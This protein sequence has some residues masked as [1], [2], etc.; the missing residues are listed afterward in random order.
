MFK[1][2][3]CILFACGLSG[4]A[5]LSVEKRTQLDDLAENNITGMKATY[6]ALEEKLETAAGYLALDAR[7]VKIPFI[8]WGGGKGVL[9][10]T[11]SGQKTYVKASR[12]D[13]GGGG[14]LREFD[15]L[16][17]IYDEKLLKIP[18]V[19]KF[20]YG[21]GA[22]ASAG[23]A[24]MEGSSSQLQTGKKFELFARSERGAS[25]TWTLKAV[26]IKPY[27]D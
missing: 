25:V 17:V 5:S 19:G 12:L 26:Y 20:Y 14:G 1:H 3:A 2:L 7:F 9:V 10:N 22:E 4:C 8:G 23:T 18:S 15:V 13:I 11:T 24:S 27:R 21:L 6:P 16:I